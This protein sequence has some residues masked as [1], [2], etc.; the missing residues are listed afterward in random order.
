MRFGKDPTKNAAYEEQ[1]P[2]SI[3]DVAAI[4]TWLEDSARAG[5]RLVGFR[6]GKG[7][8][9]RVGA[10]A[11]RYRLKPLLKRESAPDPA[12]VE[13]CRE[14]GWEYVG[15]LKGVYHI[16]RSDDPAARELDTDPVVQGEDFAY[17]RHHMARQAG[18]HLL[19]ILV[20]AGFAAWS[21]LTGETPLWTALEQDVPLQM[22][23][24]W[25]T[26]LAAV[27]LE[28]LEIRS[29]CRLICS[30]RAGI[31]LER[32]KAYRRSWRRRITRAILVVWWCVLFVVPLFRSGNF[33]PSYAWDA[34]EGDVPKPGVVYVDLRALDGVPE[35]S[36]NYSG[37]KTKIH[38]LAPR[39]YW[40]RQ[41]VENPDG[42]GRVGY[43]DSY[44]STAYYR[45][46]FPALAPVL[47]KDL[48]ARTT[49]T[50]MSKLDVE[51]PM[52]AQGPG[53]LDSFWWRSAGSW[54]TVVASRGRNVLYLQYAGPTDLRTAGGYFAELLAE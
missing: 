27:F 8:F 36:V 23:L 18:L 54:Q 7:H 30:L 33:P 10:Q 25:L 19:V 11:C 34:G 45:L 41:F 24:Y 28:C 46:L 47:E 15:T 51:T 3:Y 1:Y 29:M 22:P 14:L 26:L 43:A 44:A 49:R 38:E 31:P 9:D 53:E 42:T 35:D 13:T 6:R 20:L 2:V 37:I 32:P 4:E 5:Y 40:C 50:G 52:T 17:L 12:W 48:L 21:C 16:W 39:M